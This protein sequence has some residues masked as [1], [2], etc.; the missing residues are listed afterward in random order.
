MVQ[1]VQRFRLY[2]DYCVLIV[3]QFWKETLDMGN[4]VFKFLRRSDGEIEISGKVF[5]ILVVQVLVVSE[6]AGD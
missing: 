1:I 4:G 5:D 2:D 6:P 3:Q